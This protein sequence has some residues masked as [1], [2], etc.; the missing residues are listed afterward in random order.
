MLKSVF[1]KDNPPVY[2]IG[3]TETLLIILALTAFIV[4]KVYDVDFILADFIYGHVKWRYQNNLVTE[5][6]LHRGGR[7][8]AIMCYL[9]IIYTLV[10][11]WRTGKES[12][13]VYH[14][15]ILALTIALSVILVAVLKRLFEA[16]CPWDLL[17][18]GGNKPYFS[19]LNYDP[20]YLPSAHC[21]PASHASVGFSWLAL[22]FYLK[23]R[24][25]SMASKKRPVLVLFIV[26]VIGFV[27]GMAQ[28]FRGAHFISHDVVSL[29]ICLIT[30][31]SVY[32]LAYRR[33][34]NR[35]L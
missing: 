13:T 7:Y 22:F 16:D 27:F 20:K 32:S 29:I 18:Y 9:G 2:I 33:K 4:I 3:A 25:K 14:L 15:L 5:Y 12:E 34:R 11:K 28:Q 1:K 35:S 26:L 8:L 6:L 17:R 24:A 21:F 23:V 30:S 31:I 19:L 10:L